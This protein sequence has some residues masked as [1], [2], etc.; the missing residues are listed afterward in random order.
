MSAAL[1][2]L[3]TALRLVAVPIMIVLLLAD[4]GAQGADRWWALFVFLLAGATD[5]LDGY[6]ARRWR[7]VS[8]FGKLADP[9]ADKV[10]VLA[11]L[12]MISIVDGVPWWPVIVLALREVAVTVGRLMVAGDT[13]IAASQGGK[14]KTAL[15]VLAVTLF[16]WPNAAPWVDQVAFA[17]L[18][19]SVVLALVTGID[20]M[21]RIVAARRR[22]RAGSGDQQGSRP[23]VAA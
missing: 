1:P 7:V 10:L 14:V 5:F 4:D 11:A 20:Y 6:L 3:L 8:A 13:V 22:Q 21:R 23:D 18:I 19:A 9:I 2:N 15:Q 12:A 17:L 16:L